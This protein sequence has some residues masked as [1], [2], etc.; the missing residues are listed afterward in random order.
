MSK[1]SLVLHLRIGGQVNLCVP[2]SFSHSV[3]WYYWCLLQYSTIN[4]TAQN[5]VHTRRMVRTFRFTMVLEVCQDSL[6]QILL[7]YVVLIEVSLEKSKDVIVIS[8]KISNKR[9][10]Q[11]ARKIFLDFL[12]TFCFLSEIL[13]GKCGTDD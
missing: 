4:M 9:W 10:V 13:K 7:G 11:T 5:P 3:Y 2:C 6:V 12:F 8:S 1:P